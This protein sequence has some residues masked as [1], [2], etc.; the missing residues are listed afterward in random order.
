MRLIDA[1]ALMQTLGITDM[2][3]EKCEW[4]DH[5]HCI[6]GGDFEDAC[7]AIEDAPTIE[8]ERK[9]GRWIKM[10]DSDGVY[11]A[12]SECGKELP[13][14]KICDAE[15]VLYKGWIS[16][17]KTRYCSECGADMRGKTDEVN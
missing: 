15:T 10:S 5:N 7:S 6:R 14:V 4:G 2:D 12:C 3:C 16:L 17:A 13:R 9:T 8:P 1:D 11:W